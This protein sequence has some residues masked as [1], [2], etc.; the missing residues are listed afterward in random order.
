M[1][2]KSKA[3]PPRSFAEFFAIRQAKSDLILWHCMQHVPRGFCCLIKE[4]C[5][6]IVEISG[7]WR[8]L[9]EPPDGDIGLRSA[10][11]NLHSLT[12]GNEQSIVTN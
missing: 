9:E 10:A 3:M 11:I 1:N 8:A 6:E 12:S 7:M 5:S 4:K 2:G